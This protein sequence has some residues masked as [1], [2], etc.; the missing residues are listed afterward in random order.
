VDRELIVRAQGGEHDAFRL[1]VEGSVSRLHR[2]ARL[3]LRDD[4]RASDA[5]QDAFLQAWLDIRARRDPDRF[6]AWLYRLLVRSCY[7]EADRLRR[8]R[9]HEVHVEVLDAP[10]LPIGSD[11]V[12]RDFLERGFRALSTEH[13]AVL[14]VRHYVG[15][16]DGEAADA[17]GI[18]VG[19]Y[20]SRLNRAAS[21]LR[22]ALEAEDRTPGSVVE[23][24]V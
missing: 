10:A 7:R 11:I 24:L 6:E 9:V 4:E 14:V 23:N 12:Q 5:V 21:A 18:P 15:L 3:I 20:K 22:A 2:V 19:T 13:R 17:L 8:H 16:S 1:L